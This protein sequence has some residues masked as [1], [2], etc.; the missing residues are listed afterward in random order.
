MSAPATPPYVWVD[1][2]MGPDGTD[3]EGLVSVYED[4][5][6]F[7]D[8]GR[9]A[10]RLWFEIGRIW[11]EHLSRPDQAG[12][13]F[14]QA[15]AADPDE[16]ASGRA[17]R[18]LTSSRDDWDPLRSLLETALSDETGEFDRKT[19][20]RALAD[21]LQE[22]IGDVEP[23]PSTSEGIARPGD[24]AAQ[25]TARLT[26]LKRERGRVDAVEAQIAAE[27]EMAILCEQHLVRPDEAL[28]H[29]RAVLARDAVHAHALRGVMRLEAQTGRWSAI[30]QL[31]GRV[32]NLDVE[33]AR[34]LSYD[35]ALLVRAAMARGDQGARGHFDRPGDL[36][37]PLEHFLDVVIA[38][39]PTDDGEDAAASR[40]GWDDIDGAMLLE[41]T[42]GFELVGRWSS[43]NSVLRRLAE[44]FHGP[45]AA[46][47]WYR[48]GLNAE[49]GLR[50][51]GAA[52]EAWRKALECHQDHPPAL[53]AL[54]RHKWR[55][56]IDTELLDIID[57]LASLAGGAEARS[58]LLEHAATVCALLPPEGP[59]HEREDQLVERWQVAFDTYAE[60]RGRKP[61]GL[62]ASLHALVRLRGGRGQWD[63]LDQTLRQ[64]AERAL[65]PSARLRV[66]D[67]LAEINEVHRGQIEDAIRFNRQV[68]NEQPDHSRALSAL[69]RLETRAG[70][71][72]GAVDAVQLAL[73][74]SRDAPVA[75]RLGILTR[76][77]E[78]H[79]AMD[80]SDACESVWREAI[81]LDATYLPALIGLGRILQRQSRWDDLVELQQSVLTAMA[82]DDPERMDVMGRLGELYEFRVKDP[83]LAAEFYEKILERMPSAPDAL[84][85]LERIYTARGDWLDLVRVLTT[86]ATHIGSDPDRAFLRFRAA[87]IAYGWIGDVELALD[88][89]RQAIAADPTLMP[90][91]SA[92]EFSAWIVGAP[93]AL[94]SLY[95]ELR[96]RLRVESQRQA[97]AHKLAR[98][99]PDSTARGVWHECAE[100]GSD[101]VA[102]WALTLDAAA[103]DAP[104][105][106]ADAL[107]VV[108]HSVRS[109][110]ESAAL[111]SEVAEL[112]ERAPALAAGQKRQRW[113]RLRSL[114]EGADR[115]WEALYTLDAEASDRN[116]FASLLA[117]L[118]DSSADERTRSVS[119]W[120]AAWF[121]ARSG[122]D[123]RG[124]AHLREARRASASDPVPLWLALDANDANGHEL[125]TGPERG[126]LLEQIADRLTS[127]VLASR[128]LTEAA[129]IWGASQPDRSLDCDMRA[130]RRDP[131][132]LRPATR[133]EASLTAKGKWPELRA[134]LQV[135]ADAAPDLDRARAL[136]QQIARLELERLDDP[137]AARTTLTRLVERV[138]DDFEGR[139][140]L[141]DL[142]YDARQ[143]R[144][145]ALHYGRATDLTDERKRRVQLYVR[146]GR[147]LA[148]HLGDNR[149]GIAA[150]RRAVG[151]LD[152]DGRAIEAL[153]DICLRA[154]DAE[155]ADIAF[156]QLERLVDDPRRVEKSRAG[157]IRA[158]V[159]LE[160]TDEAVSRLRTWATRGVLDAALVAVARRFLP[161]SDVDA[162]VSLASAP[163]RAVDPPA[164]APAAALTHEVVRPPASETV[165]PLDFAGDAFSDSVGGPR[166]PTP[167]VAIAPVEA[168]GSTTP[169]DVDELE[170]V[171]D[172]LSDAPTPPLVNPATRAAT[173]E[174]ARHRIDSE[175]LDIEAWWQLRE[176]LPAGAE[177]ARA[178]L[179]EVAAW[180]G[181]TVA[182]AQATHPPGAVPAALLAPLAPRT[183]PEAILQLLRAVGPELAA[184]FSRDVSA[185]GTDAGD[186]VAAD[187]NISV[188]ARRMSSIVRPA[189]PPRALRHARLTEDGKMVARASEKN[190]PRTKE[191]PEW[192]SDGDAMVISAARLAR[193]LPVPAHEIYRHRDRPVAV[194]LEG[195]HPEGRRA[196]LVLGDAMLR[197][198]K[199]GQTFLLAHSFLQLTEGTLAAHNLSR[200]AF[201][202]FISA[203][204]GL[205]EAEMVVRPRERPLVNGF[206]KKLD[207]ILPLVWR[208]TA[209][210]IARRAATA[211]EG[212]SLVSVRADLQ[213][214]S[215]RSA[216][217]LSDGF[218]GA[219]DMLRR[220]E[221]GDRPRPVLDRGGVESFLQE[222]EMARALLRFA[223]QPECLAIRNWLRSGEI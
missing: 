118:A 110:R 100:S 97:V 180:V 191:R 13:A 50:D 222:S 137:E 85:G 190:N 90:A 9:E 73:H 136:L 89:Y 146:L 140:A 33:L 166:S 6:R 20:L 22:R 205:L 188:I 11:D 218:G 94:I 48:V 19:L 107:A 46:A 174:A 69:A 113:M 131:A 28:S 105:A 64:Y 86:H 195:G 176:T 14:E 209:A 72:E 84:S 162:I 171:A 216:L 29:Y 98:L 169:V 153:G 183:T 142:C 210:S 76:L 186:R 27:L 108:A 167:M 75:R 182:P 70:H 202:A 114:D 194:L 133:A 54:R 143:F 187:D 221:L 103:N 49:T 92:A 81:E 2:G 148:D 58:A 67:W 156:R 152:D 200:R 63:R 179:G 112:S 193:L 159:V 42:S 82:P 106:Q 47:I 135:R 185:H 31:V 213:L 77:A 201:S 3:W 15:R 35:G 173:A 1:G 178:W 125:I 154:G 7:I 91:A 164:R 119:L 78:M 56:G 149:R 37:E 160:A 139:V 217:A 168:L 26:Q 68:L 95:R 175:P 117:R 51:D 59:A 204:L 132:A 53:A 18:L 17:M 12:Q 208:A 102:A 141:A 155:S 101:P 196:A 104:A 197:A 66:L 150:L 109:P 129:E 207:G 147:T 163:A 172:M 99:L 45:S 88:L 87:E 165:D 198:D 52:V 34:A 115:A 211:L 71:V 120:R 128:A 130:V 32:A 10:S 61:M 123:D 212:I 39:L 151:L 223:A 55:Q 170:S 5:V 157:Q 158:L 189:N 203:F 215:A 65:L 25:A 116:G 219:F 145:A 161:S 199:G 36:I 122:A 74:A 41:I 111:W 220:L 134:L 83:L 138:P 184:V 16:T 4:E 60:R 80:R 96:P 57:E 206:R 124:L 121:E 93:D 177:G 214:Y 79:D 62:P 38:G 192:L 126:E 181:G 43:A 30:Q 144:R 23:E 127:G 21:Q 8:D 24:L 44:R 40:A